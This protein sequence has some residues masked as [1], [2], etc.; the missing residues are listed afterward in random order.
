VKEVY[1][2]ADLENW[3][4]KGESAIR[5]GVFGDPVAHSL[6]PQMQNAAL[7]NLGLS[8]RYA[9]FH[10]R[11]GELPTALRLIQERGFI[12]VNLTAPHK[13]AAI[14]LLD[15][16]D[17]QARIIGAVNTVA[18]RTGKSTGFNTDGEGFAQ[19]LFEDT[20][21][22]VTGFRVLLA[23]SG[24]AARAIAAQ[25]VTHDAEKVMLCSRS[26]G[27]AEELAERLAPH[28]NETVVTV[29]DASSDEL[30]AALLDT[31]ILVSTIPADSDLLLRPVAS[32]KGLHLLLALYDINYTAALTPLM[33]HGEPVAT[34]RFNGL[35]MLLHQGAL[36]FEIWFDRAA[37]LDAMRSALPFT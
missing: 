23:G 13:I 31:E 11:A 32:L 8:E 14:E 10:I 36:A 16:V 3:K 17:E 33:R 4:K 35:S 27:S 34:L 28:T 6:S 29:V 20:G 7:E 9:R 25:C 12:G 24:G 26:R 15:E 19:A 37:P 5:L 2:L 30:N 22:F 21:F 18:F 1:T